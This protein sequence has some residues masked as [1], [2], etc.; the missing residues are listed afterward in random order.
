MLHR[1]PDGELG[2]VSVCARAIPATFGEQTIMLDPEKVREIFRR[3]MAREPGHVHGDFLTA[4]A[5]AVVRA[6]HENFEILMG[7]AV[8]LI[9]KYRLNIKR[10]GA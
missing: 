1:L 10:E 8:F 5:E 4:F 2:K 3:I 7:A 9:C 6:D